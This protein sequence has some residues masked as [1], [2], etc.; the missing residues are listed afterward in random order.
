MGIAGALKEPEQHWLRLISWAAVSRVSNISGANWATIGRQFNDRDGGSRLVSFLKGDS[1]E[2]NYSHSPGYAGGLLHGG[3]SASAEPRGPSH[4]TLQLYR[5][6]QTASGRHL[7]VLPEQRGHHR[8]SES[9]STNY[10][11]EHGSKEELRRA[12]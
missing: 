12:G 5:R 6:R 8:H 9:Q 10:D 2:A 1:H 4:H 7:Q 3:S 11:P